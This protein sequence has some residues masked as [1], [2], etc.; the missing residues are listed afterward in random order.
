VAPNDFNIQDINDAG[1]FAGQHE[2]DAIF[3]APKATCSYTELPTFDGPCEPQALSEAGGVGW[4]GQVVGWCEVSGG[5]Q[6]AC[7]WQYLA[8]AGWVV[9][10]LN[11]LILPG[12]GWDRLIGATDINAAGD[13]VGWGEIDGDE[14]AFL[15]TLHT[16]PACCKPDGS[17]SQIE[18]E[19]CVSQGG[20][21]LGP[22]S[23]CLGD[24]DS[25][26]IDDACQIGCCLDE[27]LGQCDTITVAVTCNGRVLL[28]CLGD[29]DSN[30]SDDACEVEACCDTNGTCTDLYVLDCSTQGG[31]SQGPGTVCTN[32]QACCLAGGACADVDPLCCDDLDGTPMGFGTQCLTDTNTNGFA[33]ACEEA[34]CFF[35]TALCEDLPPDVCR[36][37][38]G[39]PQG[40][41]THCHSVVCPPAIPTLSEWGLIFMGLLMLGAGVTVLARRRS[42]TTTA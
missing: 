23:Q 34:C 6:H 38:Q 21:P 37:Q 5:S 19:D 12:S 33:D 15:L 22:G 41:G 42:S 1:Q 31:T 14:H 24:L 25:N 16:P 17:C 7:M 20:E 30:G 8:P 3:G 39:R 10:D 27:P 13:I 9:Y 26:G 35:Y 28:E 4:A 18:Y 29:A 36:A 32:P 11:D 2:D 40:P